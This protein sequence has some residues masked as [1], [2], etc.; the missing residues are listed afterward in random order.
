MNLKV[1]SGPAVRA[2]AAVTAVA[3]IPAF[4][5]FTLTAVSSELDSTPPLDNALLLERLESREARLADDLGEVQAW[6]RRDVVPVEQVLRPF[7]E[8]ERWIRR[9]SLALVREGRNVEMDPRVLASVL[10]VENPW[11]DATARSTQGAV[12]LM[13]VMPFHAGDWGCPS[14]D[15]TVAEVNICHGARIFAHYLDRHDG[16][17]DRAL[18]AYNGCVRG[19]N[20]PNCHTYPGHVYA[21]AG[22]A[23]FQRWLS[24]D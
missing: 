3:A 5:A 18:L 12:G 4:V 13:Q 8:D 19:T 14:P 23:A 15:L 6:Y 21:R 20:T 9:I 7:H 24:M 16:D 17:I 11:L 1:L 2:L 10:L 22:R